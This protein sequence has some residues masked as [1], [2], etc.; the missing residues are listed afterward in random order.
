MNKI[1]S[2]LILLLLFCVKSFALKDTLK[3]GNFEF[4]ENKGQWEQCVLYKSNIKNGNIYLEKN[5]FTVDLLRISDIEHSHAHDGFADDDNRYKPIHRHAYK[6]N[7]LNSNPSVSIFPAEK[8]TD[9]CNFFIGNDE[10]KW[11]SHVRK[12]KS[13][14]YKGLYN[15][16]DL[17]VFSNQNTFKY[18]FIIHP[19]GNPHDIEIEYNGVDNIKVLNEQLLI[20]TSVDRIFE[21]KPFAYQEISGKAV[22]VK[23]KY[24]LKKNKVRFQP[25]EYNSNYPLIIDPALVFS[26]YTGSGSDNW[27]FTATFDLQGNVYSGGI[28]DGTDYPVSTGAYD[29]TFRG[30]WDV[31]IIKYDPTGTSRLYAS[32]LGGS[33]SEMPHSLI[34]NEFNE[35]QIFGTTG[36]ANFPTSAGA[37]DRTFN[38]GTTIYYDNTVV[39]NNG[40]DIFVS[41]LSP[42]GSQLRASTF[43]GGS[44]NDG[45]N[46]RPGYAA[47]MMHGN[48]S[49]Y[50][51]YADGA[52]GEIITDDRNNV[53]IGTCTFST[54]FPT[55][56]NAYQRFSGGRQD[57]IVFKL[58]YNLSNLIW[59]SYIGGSGDDAIYSVDVDSHYDLYVAG[60]TNSV[61]FPTTSGAYRTSYLGGSADAFLSHFSQNGNVLMQS[62][63]FGSP[64]YD[65]AYF[66][67]TDKYNNAFI[68]GQTKA[69]GS[70]LIYNASYSRPNSGQFIAKFNPILTNLVWSTTFGTGNGKP[71]ISPTAFAVDIC[72]RIYVS[73]WGREWA[74]HSPYNDWTAT[75]GTKNMD[76]TPGAYQDTT[77][78]QDFYVMVM[79]DDASALDYAT[80]FG[81]LHYDA[82]WYSGHDHVDGGTSRFD[83]RGSIYQ[84]VCAS[85]GACNQFPT[86]PNPGAWSNSNRS[87]NCNNAI[88]KFNIFN[89]FTLAEFTMPNIGCAPHTVNFNNTSDGVTFQWDFGDGSLFS[90]QRN[91]THTYTH[92]GVFNVTLIAID[93]SSCNTAD[94]MIRQI[95]ILSDTTYRLPD[96]NMCPG[97]MRQIGVTPNPDTTVTYRWVPSSGINDPTVS[98]PFAS[99]SVSTNYTLFVS[100]G[101][102]TDTIHQN[103]N[104]VHIS[105]NAGNDTLTCSGSTRLTAFTG[106]TGLSY[107]W[108]TN[109]NFTDT[110]NHPVTN[111]IIYVTVTQSTMY[112]VMAFIDGCWG[113]DSVKVD[114][115]NFIGTSVIVNPLCHDDCTGQITITPNGG[116]AP[117]HFVWSNGSVLPQLDSLCAGI[118]HVTI[119]DNAGCIS[120]S[121]LE[122]VQPD[123]LA[124]N[125]QSTNIPCTEVCNGTVNP[126]ILGGTQPYNYI[127]S[128]SSTASAL[129]DL[130]PGIYSVTITDIHNCRVFLTD[131]VFLKPILVNIHAY[132][133][134]DTIYNGLNTTL[135]VNYIPGITYNWSPQGSLSDPHSPNPV[136]SPTQSTMYYVTV[137]DPY[138][139][140]AVDSVPIVVIDVYCYEPYIFVPNAFTPNADQNNDVLFVRSNYIENLTFSVYDRWGEKVFETNDITK[141]WNGRYKGRDCDPGVYVFHLDATCFNLKPFSKKGNVTLI[142]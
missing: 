17:K 139:C 50:F 63:F 44:G 123:L 53:Y 138:G 64:V 116:T 15:D 28:V 76:I 130:C 66:V 90:T 2:I 72:R 88:F 124:G 14:M 57:G 118:Y 121:D 73:G 55:T 33:S 68:F 141:G 54:D 92:S 86:F 25:E 9:Y 26:T 51:N 93:H 110:L 99:P 21:L 125:I 120:M 79:A 6:M 1:F 4:S 29:E 13:V 36:S 98:N 108:S 20:T 48:D 46:F 126:N 11:A 94:T 52:R 32:Y 127:W 117:Y 56:S 101:I 89:N 119:T 45:L 105:V 37:Y 107:I 67:R 62:T 61:N 96:I 39:F 84:S 135:H 132:A 16:V 142:R 60:G 103:V 136:A 87:T 111:N 133:D 30:I 114:L 104:I 35:L 134:K 137:T 102:C 113:I 24:V 77:D 83:K 82:C 58:D 41:R 23:C 38:G 74:G 112:Y 131:T 80:Y 42:D 8:T 75:E 65:Q 47:V 78:G 18:E 27:G 140:M 10:S 19:G 12:Y 128:N 3:S 31:A 91:P 7:F 97:D 43:I 69:S 109:R 70:T 49:L 40:V 81:E 85:C 95:Q 71:N 129:I 106:Q 122:V 100:N 115:M 22:E 34:V 5:C 59:S